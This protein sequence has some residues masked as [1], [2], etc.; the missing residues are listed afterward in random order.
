MDAGETEGTL[1]TR[2]VRFGGR[3][4]FVN[5]DAP[6]GE[7]RVEVLDE[8]GRTLPAFSRA[9][10]VPVRAD[11]TLQAI[12]WQGKDDLSSLTGR[13]VR[14]RFHLRGGRLY[15]FWVCADESGASRGF[16]AAGGPGFT[17]PTD[18]VGSAGAPVGAR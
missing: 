9:R 14:F 12:R 18:T 8:R 10:C 17:G 11:R 1:T 5:V 13:P 6:A 16:V 7:L 4:L 3:R 15:S 2:P